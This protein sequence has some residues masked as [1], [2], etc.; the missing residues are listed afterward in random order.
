M[1]SLVSDLA[2]LVDTDARVRRTKIDTD[3]SVDLLLL[4]ATLTFG[5]LSRYPPQ[6]LQTAPCCQRETLQIPGTG[7][8]NRKC[9]RKPSN[10]VN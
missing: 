6:N 9:V 2:V 8:L 7:A 3:G 5:F 10:P 4:A 1:H